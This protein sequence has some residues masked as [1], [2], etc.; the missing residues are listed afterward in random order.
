MWIL[1]FYE[2]VL[3]YVDIAL[4][5]LVLWKQFHWAVD[6][7]LKQFFGPAVHTVTSV[8]GDNDYYVAASAGLYSVA[9]ATTGHTQL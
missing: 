3:H 9:S 1:L 4:P 2:N 7:A 6:I 8:H 5:K